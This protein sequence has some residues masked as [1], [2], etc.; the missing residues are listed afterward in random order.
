MLKYIKQGYYVA[1]AKQDQNLT[2]RPD[3]IA[4]P[5]D[6]ASLRTMYDK[7]I[8]IEVESCNELSVHP[9]QVVHNWRKESTK[10]FS[11][12]HSWTY[13]ECFD[14]LQQLYNQLSDAEKNK[15]KIF[16]IKLKKE[17]EQQSKEEQKKVEET[18]EF[19]GK[20][21]EKAESI[22]QQAA[23]GATANNVTNS[24]LGS[25]TQSKNTTIEQQPGDKEALVEVEIEGKNYFVKEQITK[26]CSKSSVLRIT[27][28]KGIKY[29]LK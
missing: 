26:N 2:S 24:K 11:E 17:I 20:R 27:K 29:M 25:L 6:K 4:I 3:L 21:E 10:D 14:K 15:V 23:Q 5:I 1:P 19:N 9:E 28:L 13:E 7:T 12:I 16:S 8:A 18:G 22:A